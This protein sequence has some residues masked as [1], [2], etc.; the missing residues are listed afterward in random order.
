M[1]TCFHHRIKKKRKIAT[2]YLLMFFLQLFISELQ[3][4]KSCQTK[5]AI[6]LFIHFFI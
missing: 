4:L 1:E 3:I 2:F 5:V 6:I